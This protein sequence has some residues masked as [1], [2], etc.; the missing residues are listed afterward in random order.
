MTETD[1]KRFSDIQKKVVWGL[2]LQDQR[3]LVRLADK[4]DKTL[5]ERTIVGKDTKDRVREN[6]RA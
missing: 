1:R 6:A 4:L 3:W 2:T 5:T